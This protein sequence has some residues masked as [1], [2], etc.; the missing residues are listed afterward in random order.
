[1]G[2]NIS[3]AMHGGKRPGLTAD[4]SSPLT[5]AQAADMLRVTLTA[6]RA[7]DPEGGVRVIR[8]RWF[9]G[10]PQ[11]VIVTGDREARQ[12]AF[13]AV[14]GRPSSDTGPGYPRTDMPFGWR[15]DQIA[16]QIHRGD[17]FGPAGRWVDVAAGLALLY[18]CVSGGWIYLDLWRKRRRIGRHG[19]FW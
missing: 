2:V 6:Y 19:L 4:V 9:A 11:G 3:Q 16:K 18:L 13:D 5:D 10:V 17:F 8:L 1:V 14:T 12:V 15:V 7:A